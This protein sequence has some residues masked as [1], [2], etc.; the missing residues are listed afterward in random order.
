LRT[1]PNIRSGA[2]KDQ[3]API[4]EKKARREAKKQAIKEQK[5]LNKKLKK[6][7]HMEVEESD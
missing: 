6:E 1:Q 3:P 5:K 2:N 7:Q 4:T